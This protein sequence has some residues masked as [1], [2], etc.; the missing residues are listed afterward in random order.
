MSKKKNPANRPASP[1]RHPA[2]TPPPRPHPNPAINRVGAA[3]PPQ[4]LPCRS[5]GPRENSTRNSPIET[6]WKA[7]R[8]L[9][10]SSR[11]RPKKTMKAVVIHEAGGPDVLKVEDRPVPTV[12][13]GWLPIRV[14]AFGLNRSE[15]FTRQ[16]HWPNVI[17]PRVP[18]IEAVGEVADPWDSDFAMGDTVA[19]AMGGMGRAS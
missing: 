14:R 19:A 10:G 11:E 6:A 3:R 13:P 2:R 18:G 7:G 17:F 12:K 16:G 8:R 1:A 9:S 15:L 5:I 4:T